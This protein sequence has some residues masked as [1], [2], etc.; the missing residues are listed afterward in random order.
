VSN[1]T[2]EAAERGIREIEGLFV[3]KGWR[4]RLHEEDNGT[5]TAAFWLGPIPGEN[6]NT[7]ARMAHEVTAPT[8]LDAAEVAWAKYQQ[9]PF[10]GGGSES[11]RSG[12]GK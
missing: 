3:E 1:V 8:A 4:L 7:S 9:E 6:L 5:W 10:L 11:E 2:D 12:V